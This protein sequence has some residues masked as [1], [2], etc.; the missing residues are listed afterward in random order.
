MPI[1]LIDYTNSEEGQKGTPLDGLCKGEWELPKQIEELEAWLKVTGF[2]LPKGDYVADIGYS[3][4]VGA[5][6]GGAVL[7]PEAMGIMSAV[8][9]TLYFSEYPN[10]Q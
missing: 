1:N 8:G 6:G 10:E 5:L 7:K 9:I 4:R 3:P 2:K